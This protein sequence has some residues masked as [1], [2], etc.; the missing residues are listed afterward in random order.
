MGDT[1][2]TAF[3]GGIDLGGT[4]I[5]ARLFDG[6]W[7]EVARNRIATPQGDYDALLGAAVQQARWLR[8]RA[9]H[10]C[11]GLG[12]PGLIDR[13]TGRMMA[14]NLPLTGRRFAPDMADALGFAVPC[15][16]DSRAFALS[17]ARL[18]AGRG[19]GGV[20]GLIL[21]TGVAG[22]YARDGKVLDGPNG[23]AG[24]VGHLSLPADLVARHNLP[25]LACGCGRHGCFET[26]L[27]G[28]GLTRLADSMTGRAAPGEEV[29]RAPEFAPVRAVWIALLAELIV[30]LGFTHDPDMVV[31]GGGVSLMPDL[32]ERLQAEL[33]SHQLSGTRAP[34]LRLAEGG[35]ASGARGAALFALEHRAA[36]DPGDHTER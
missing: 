9:P 21:G 6:T 29:G 35:D 33:P 30:A 26:L 16:C 36:P 13:S 10:G 20:F 3:C 32:L 18:G 11:I 2:I 5:E 31:L 25:V 8:A 28:P 24:E 27:S 22:G 17:E 14:A 4:K 7:H 1:D 19:L 34:A 12:L 23:Q 15:I